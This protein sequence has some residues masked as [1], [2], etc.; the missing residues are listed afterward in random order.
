LSF[1]PDSRQRLAA[2]G[3]C[4]LKKKILALCDGEEYYAQHMSQ[5]LRS[6]KEIPWEI[7]TFTSPDS[8]L[9]ADCETHPDL[10]V[11][12]ENICTEEILTLWP[13]RTV[14]LNESGILRG[15]T[16]K[17]IDKFQRAD[18]VYQ[19]LLTIYM[20]WGESEPLSPIL[21]ITAMQKDMVLIGLYSPVRRCLQTSFALTLGQMLAD[22][23]KTLYLNFEHYAGFGQL[24]PNLQIRDLSDLLYFLTA[25]KEKFLL[26]MQTVKKQIGNL[27]LIPPVKAG[28]QL[29]QVTREEWMEFLTKIFE[30]GQYKYI[31][32]D[33]SESVQGLMD[34]LRLCKTV[35]TLTKEDH[36]SQSKLDQYEQVLCLYAY[37]D[38]LQKTRKCRPPVFRRLPDQIEQFT[39]GELGDYVRGIMEE[40]LH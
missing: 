25:D 13:S 38:V 21:P 8:L 12:S 35:F 5:Y 28:E 20:E 17:N 32:L 37:E 19:E 36:M 39:K 31:I 10:L 9:Q 7:L 4:L 3:R 15:T 29:I 33:L 24:L 18:L 40:L 16:V 26:W 6:H 34:I 2:F 11:V 30:L 27:E 14:I 1:R 23:D 22:R